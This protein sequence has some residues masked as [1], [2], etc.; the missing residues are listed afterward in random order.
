MSE[1]PASIPPAP[2]GGGSNVEQS[3]SGSGNPGPPA[4][5]RP[6]SEPEK[7][8]SQTP[9]SAPS[10]LPNWLKVFLVIVPAIALLVSACSFM[11]AYRA[12]RFSMG[13]S[14]PNEDHDVVARVLKVSTR[15]GMTG[16]ELFVDL[17]LINKGNQNEIIRDAFLCYAPNDDFQSS[18]SGRTLQFT[19]EQLNIQLSKGDR[20]VL[21]LSTP[22]NSFNTGKKMWLGV[23]VRAIAPNADEIEIAWPVC[24]INLA[25]DG[26]GGQIS[27]SKDQT[28]LIRIISNDRLPHQKIAP[29]VP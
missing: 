18:A 10:E 7:H 2:T 4:V 8:E 9:A 21:H 27:Y 14:R 25:F 22:F 3:T 5:G 16:S 26:K 24:E 6:A 20:R 12:L 13:Y 17:A 15:Y 28:P 23:A 19:G 29:E 11:V 1:N